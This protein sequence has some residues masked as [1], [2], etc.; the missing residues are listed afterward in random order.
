IQEAGDEAAHDTGSATRK[1]A[2][3]TAPAKPTNGAPNARAPK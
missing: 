2:N 1:A 3:Q